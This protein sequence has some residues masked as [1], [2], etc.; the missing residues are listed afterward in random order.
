M[1]IGRVDAIWRC[2]RT[3]LNAIL[4]PPQGAPERMRRV[5]VTV[6]NEIGM[7]VTIEPTGNL[8]TLLGN[9]RANRDLS[10]GAF[11]LPAAGPQLGVGETLL[12]GTFN[13]LCL[14]EDALALVAFA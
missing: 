9:R 10:G 14:S 11:M 5:A 3:R 6:E 8:G 13:R 4:A 2:M 1:I 12:F 7:A